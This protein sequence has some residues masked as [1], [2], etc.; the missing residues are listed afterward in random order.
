MSKI[1]KDRQVD[2]LFTQRIHTYVYLNGV[3]C[4]ALLFCRF[5]AGVS[6]SG[7]QEFV[8]VGERIQ[9]RV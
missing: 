2:V 6:C 4:R 7:Y 1:W 8:A 9:Q 3:C 5:L